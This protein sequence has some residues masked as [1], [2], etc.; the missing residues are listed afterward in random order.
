MS[1]RDPATA[2][3]SATSEP[4][5]E[6]LQPANN[7]S[8]TTEP[9]D[10]AVINRSDGYQLRQPDISE[11]LRDPITK[12]AGRY[13]YGCLVVLVGLLGLIARGGLGGERGRRLHSL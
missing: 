3:Q 12:I 7:H 2:H 9:G 8:E 5:D 10:Q 11:W 13:D 1:K 6:N 4:N